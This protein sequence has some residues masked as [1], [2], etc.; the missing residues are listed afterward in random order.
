[1]IV[2]FL[3]R[4]TKEFCF[5]ASWFFVTLQVHGCCI[6]VVFFLCFTNNW[7]VSHSWFYKIFTRTFPTVSLMTNKLL[8]FSD[9]NHQQ[10]SFL[11]KAFSFID[12][13]FKFIPFRLFRLKN[14]KLFELSCRLWWFSLLYQLFMQFFT[15]CIQKVSLKSRVDEIPLCDQ[16]IK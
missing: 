12:N 7:I 4:C 5:S 2:L 1:M 10:L 11:L 15:A 14:Y 16:R 8:L 9:A 13:F 3:A 6:N